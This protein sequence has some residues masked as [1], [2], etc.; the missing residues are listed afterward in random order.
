MKLFSL[1]WGLY[2]LIFISIFSIF[3]ISSYSAQVIENYE[4]YIDVISPTEFNITKVLNIRNRADSGLIPG[5]IIFDISAEDN[6]ISDFNA[7]DNLNNDLSVDFD[8]IRNRLIVNNYIPIP[9]GF[10][11]KVTLE[12][13]MDIENSGIFFYEIM[14]PISRSAIDVEEVNFYFSSEDYHFSYV[15]GANKT[16]MNDKE[17]VHLDFNDVPEDPI[18]VEFTKIPLMLLPFSGIYLFWLPL[19]LLPLI[20]SLIL[21]FYKKK[22]EKSKYDHLKW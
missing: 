8:P 4:L 10:S 9:S 17:F 2:L 20:F 7:Y 1:K 11:Q 13:M 14:Y 19:I 16:E 3:S 5:E 6:Q 21:F 15:P 18:H 22:K 12:Y